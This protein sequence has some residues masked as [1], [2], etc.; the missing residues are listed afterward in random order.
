MASKLRN[1]YVIGEENFNNWSQGY[2]SNGYLKVLPHP[3]EK[4]PFQ[5]PFKDWQEDRPGNYYSS[6][7]PEENLEVTLTTETLDQIEIDGLGILQAGDGLIPWLDDRETPYETLRGY[8]GLVPGPMLIV[9]PGD[10]LNIELINNLEDPEELMNLHTHGLH[11]SP[12][13]N[14]DNVLLSIGKGETWLVEIEIPKDHFIGTDWYHPH[15]HGVTNEQVSSGLGGL[16]II[17]PPHDLPDLDKFNIKEESVHFLALNSFGIQQV[18]RE[19]QANDPLNQNLNL[20]IPAGTPLEVLEEGENGE[21]TYELS[22]S[23]YMG[24]NAKPELYDST[25]PLGDTEDSLS[26]YGEGLLAE[27]VENVI[28]TVNGQ[29]NPTMELETGEWNLFSFAN[30]SANSFHRVQLVKE[31]GDRLIPQEVF[32]VAIDGDASGVVS[33]TRREITEFPILN[34]G[35]RINIQHWFEESGK[36]YFLSNGTEEFMGDDAPI[37]TKDKGFNDGHLI[38]G[39]QVLATVE[40]TGEEMASDSFPESY[41]TLE[42]QSQEL[43]EIIQAARNGEF[44]RKR[45][46]V[47]SANLGGA[48][49]EGRTPE[50]TDV[51]SFEG[52]YTIN[53]EYYATDGSGMPPLTMP[54]L[55]TTEV[56]NIVNESG[57]SNE[58]LPLDQPLAEWH[59]FHIHQ[60][61]FVVLEINGIP[62]EDI[63]Q[64]YLAGVLSD[65]VALPPTHQPGSVT[66]QNPY[67][68]AQ[69]GGTPSEVKIL[70]DFEDYPGSYVNHCHILFHEDAGMMAVVRVILNTEDTWLGLGN[71]QGDSDGTEIELIKANSFE[72][73]ISLKPYGTEFTGGIDIAI[74]DVNYKQELENNNVTDNVTDVV[75]I[76]SS[77]DNSQADFTVKVFDGQTLID[78]Q[79]QGRREFDGEESLITE[80]TPFEEIEVSSEQVASVAAGDIN[81]D[82]YADI[83]VG[84]GGGISPLIEIYSGKD[85]ELLSRITPF[86]EEEFDGDFN[87][88]VGD[89]NGDNFEDLIVGQGK[90]GEGFLEVYDG[91]LIDTQGN[92]NGHETAQKTALLSEPFQPYGDT[93]TG[94]IEVTSGYILQKPSEPNGERVQ[95]NNANITTMAVDDLPEEQEQIRVFTYQGGAHS[96]H[97]G[98]DDTMEM[99]QEHHENTGHSMEMEGGDS[100]KQSM[101]DASMEM[102]E[103]DVHN[104]EEI[105]LE[106]EFT[107][108]SDLEEFAGT[109]ADLPGL[110]RGESVLFGQSEDG[111]SEIIRLQEQNLPKSYTLA[112]DSRQLLGTDEAETMLG[113]A[114]DNIIVAG[115]GNDKIFGGEG[116]DLVVA[117]VGNDTV[118]GGSGRDNIF[119][120]RGNDVLRGNTDNDNL[121][122]DNGRDTLYGGR[123]DDYLVGGRGNDILNGK[124]GNDTL[125]GAGIT[126][127]LLEATEEDT[128]SQSIDTLTGGAGNNLFVLGN[129]THPFYDDGDA[130]TTGETDLATITDF[131]V[132]EDSLQLFGEAKDYSL[133]LFATDTGTI[134]ADLLYDSGATARRELI[135]TLENVPDNL[136]LDDITITFV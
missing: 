14:G 33:D 52:T 45:T 6:W 95:T 16:L 91:R 128:G 125:T 79:E 73:G 80:F 93:Y 105:R 57:K 30:M 58:N 66:P 77:L 15:M 120:D 94:E 92:L 85:Y 84:I 103:D 62:V 1:A 29:Y 70:M 2:D 96:H 126:D 12:V 5:D 75:S 69:V 97:G 53:G 11:V 71:K 51:K 136:T 54:M 21:K 135:A 64:N 111:N 113:L 115:G 44:D 118:L 131:E 101:E 132:S 116:F 17:N 123:G 65:T 104:S 67:G 25:Q 63:D 47:W 122:G 72:E 102:E 37:L 81:G 32:L 82:G 99:T 83:A 13:G 8:N 88:A 59:P 76:Q 117:G 61:D 22:D 49:A 114:E 90:G 110:P 50:D 124:A 24:F 107:P 130:T 27:P 46:F 43:D 60:N 3:D 100:Q 19:G 121:F 23:V 31:E 28:H 10:T 78:Q 109:F 41:D 34:P 127:L 108:Y 18:E 48:S 42:E 35:S 7:G 119:G 36:Y 39:S 133:D 26:A 87:L 98:S 129:A 74:A 20:A 68:I 9:E 112:T 89:A 4:I 55:G 38:W 134:N 86:S 40:V 106:T 56:W